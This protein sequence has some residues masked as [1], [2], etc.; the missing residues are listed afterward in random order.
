MD[1]KNFN[2]FFNL[3][4]NNSKLKKDMKRQDNQAPDEA[5]LTLWI[6]GELSG[7]ELAAVRAMQSNIQANMPASVEPPYADFFNQRILQAIEN[8][9]AESA[10][11]VRST[12]SQWLGNKLNKWLALPAAAAA[13]V[14][15]FYMGTQ[16]SHMPDSV[17]PVAA[18]SAV[19]VEPAIYMPD[20]DVRAN[21]FSSDDNG[22]TVIVLEGLED[23]PDDFEIVGEPR[24]SRSASSRV[25]TVNTEM[26]F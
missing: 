4:S 2:S 10:A 6:D 5:M 7:D 13:M 1:G 20:G 11:R 22:A 21:I 9:K 12:G 8:E 19:S 25:V 3:K 16:V 26:V 23:I 18:V 17:A 15:C 14:M 24:H